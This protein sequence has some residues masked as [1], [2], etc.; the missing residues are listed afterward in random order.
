MDINRG[1][2]HRSEI[3]RGKACSP[4]GVSKNITKKIQNYYFNLNDIL[5]KGSF[6][7]VYRGIE[8]K[9]EEVVAVKVIELNKI[10]SPTLKEL[11]YSE[12]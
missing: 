5:G 8:E 2:N 11:L 9:T 6:S 7:T 3:R 4:E 1:Y 10:E 12:I